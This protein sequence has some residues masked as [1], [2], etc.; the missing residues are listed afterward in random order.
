MHN[1]ICHAKAFVTETRKT[2]FSKYVQDKLLSRKI[3]SH[4]F[5][6]VNRGIYPPKYVSLSLRTPIFWNPIEPK[7]SS[8][9]LLSDWEIISRH[10]SLLPKSSVIDS[11]SLRV[12]ALVRSWIFSMTRSLPKEICNFPLCEVQT[13]QLRGNQTSLN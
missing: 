2:H 7:F 11:V 13:Q 1:E 3:I 8:W 6:F 5:V 10:K 12:F 9:L 4:V